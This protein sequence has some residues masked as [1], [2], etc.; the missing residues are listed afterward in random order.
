[1]KTFG[2]W[3]YEELVD[4]IGVGK[5]SIILTV[6]SG[7]SF[8]VKVNSLRMECFKNDPSCLYCKKRVGT[9]W[10]L[11]SHKNEY[12]H[13][14]LYAIGK[15]DGLILMTK[16]HVIPKSRG[17]D[18]KLWNLVTACTNCNCSKGDKIVTEYMTCPP[19]NKIIPAK[20]G[21]VVL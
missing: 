2:F 19:M 13:L 4:L 21:T 9:L 1:M 11:E 7:E 18:D 15:K 6:P 12:P 3:F 5:T 16:D 14:N 8:E 17:G 10:V 20:L